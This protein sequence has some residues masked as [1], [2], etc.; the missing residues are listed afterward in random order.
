MSQVTSPDGRVLIQ[1][2]PDQIGVLEVDIDPWLADDKMITKYDDVIMARKP[3][4]Y[5]RLVRP[6]SADPSLDRS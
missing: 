4:L 3:E 2:S 5:W 1:A 6:T